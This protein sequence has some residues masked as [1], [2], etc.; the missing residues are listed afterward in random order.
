MSDL[1]RGVRA[2]QMPQ[3]SEIAEKLARSTVDLP[4]HEFVDPLEE[5]AVK[6]VPH[7]VIGAAVDGNLDALAEIHD[8]YSGRILIFCSRNVPIDDVEDVTQEVWYRVCK[9]MENFEFTGVPLSSWV[10]RIARNT[11]LSRL[12]RLKKETSMVRAHSLIGVPLEERDDPAMKVKDDTVDGSPERKLLHNYMGRVVETLISLLPPEQRTVV[13]LRYQLER[14]IAE[15]A[16]L[17]GKTESNVK[18]LSSKGVNNMRK[19]LIPTGMTSDILS[20]H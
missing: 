16:A 9:N 1:E 5:P 4:K 8:T 14:T 7:R 6:E 12:R 19:R 17:T 13:T 20:E 15:T 10:Y 3:I 2:R 18:A 11:C